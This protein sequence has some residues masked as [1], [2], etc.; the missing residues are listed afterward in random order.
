[1]SL[2]SKAFLQVQFANGARPDQEAF[3]DVF[4]SFVHKEEDLGEGL[5]LGAG[6]TLG[7]ADDDAENG[8]IR[9]RNN[10]FEFKYNGVWESLGTGSGGA[11]APINQADPNVVYNGGNVGINLRANQS[12]Q[13]KLEV[14]IDQN[15]A[16][17]NVAEQVRFGNA[18]LTRGRNAFANDAV[19]AHRDNANDD[20]FAL[21]QAS[22]GVVTVH[23]PAAT[24]TTFRQ[25][26][27]KQGNL[28]RPSGLALTTTGHVAVNSNNTVSGA[29]T[30]TN[31]EVFQVNG[32]AY[33][34]GDIRATG[35][36]S[37]RTISP[38]DV[39][40]K[41]NVQPFDDG[42]AMLRQVMPVQWKFNGKA[43]TKEGQHAVGVIAQDLQKIFPEMVLALPRKMDVED[44][45]ESDVLHVKTPDL[46]FVMINAIKELASKV[47]SLESEVAAL[48]AGAS[49][50]R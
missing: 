33:V 25:I 31:A 18:V 1:M 28:A 41:E 2:Q 38:S 40:L 34:R 45:K 50:T 3:Q 8:T 21:S 23:A 35:D 49:G 19:F 16:T 10:I 12:P 24:G 48:K 36:V 6:V 43:G 30:T 29:N 17:G 14:D 46:T 44:P 42:L 11:F 27:F 39:R 9:F 13:Y 47:E 26:Q 32:N 20:S 37:G 7:D 4:D 15:T 5:E 22:S